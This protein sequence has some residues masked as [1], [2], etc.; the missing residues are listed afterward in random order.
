M[1][2]GIATL[3]LCTLTTGTSALSPLTPRLAPETH[4]ELQAGLARAR[5]PGVTH[6]S[7]VLA[8]TGALGIAPADGLIDYKTGY[9][10]LPWVKGRVTRLSGQ[11]SRVEARAGMPAESEADAVVV[12]GT[13]CLVRP[14]EWS[15]SDQRVARPPG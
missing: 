5:L 10:H 2:R 14:A 11:C 13:Y 9:P 7:V 8:I 1:K 3:L 12:D 15:S 4:A 6:N